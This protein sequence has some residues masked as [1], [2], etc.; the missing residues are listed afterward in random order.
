MPEVIAS[1]EC[2]RIKDQ[3]L[4]IKMIAEQHL[5]INLRADHPV[6]AD[7]TEG[8]SLELSRLHDYPYV[9]YHSSVDDVIHPLDFS[10]PSLSLIHISEP[11][12]H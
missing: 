3:G 12:R 4:S 2:Q 10:H 11:T 6:L 1:I 9:S 8:Q 5:N 7:Y